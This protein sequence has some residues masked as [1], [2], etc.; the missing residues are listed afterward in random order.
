MVCL[1]V[2]FFLTGITVLIVGFT[3][4]YKAIT[5]PVRCLWNL[6]AASFTVGM[7]LLGIFKIAGVPNSVFL[8]PIWI[9]GAL[10]A[11][12]CVGFLIFNIRK[13]LEEI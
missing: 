11:L 6:S 9:G 10:T 1:L 2:P 13:H 7:A 8:V 12:A 3:R 5:L 4:F